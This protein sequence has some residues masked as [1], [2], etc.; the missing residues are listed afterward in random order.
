MEIDKF[1]LDENESN[2]IFSDLTKKSKRII[3]NQE[4]NKNNHFE[5]SIIK[6]G[7]KNS[8]DKKDKMPSFMKTNDE[9]GKIF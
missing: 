2:I 3:N 1:R 7:I 4:N 6:T 8:L 5:E 9:L